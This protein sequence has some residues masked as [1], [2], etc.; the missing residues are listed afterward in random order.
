MISWNEVKQYLPQYLTAEST[1][2]LFDQLK[3]FPDNI[4][5]RL[6]TT[7]LKDK[8]FI[9]QGDGFSS[10]PF[11]FFPDKETFE[12]PAMILSN[13]C[14]NV[15]RENTYTPIHLIYAPIIKM[16]NFINLLRD[17]GIEQDKINNYISTIKKQ[18]VTQIFYLPVGDGVKEES[19]VFFDKINNSQNM[20]EKEHIAE[21]RLFSFSDYGFYLL[22]LKISIH[23]TRIR[24]KIDRNEGIVF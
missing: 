11:V 12:N 13:T 18:Y 15:V 19:L 14:D 23:F 22:L 17:N 16:S 6:Y 5:S 10:F 20:V 4:D 3:Q 1:Q 21:R 24:E 9:F 2:I 8:T 7:R